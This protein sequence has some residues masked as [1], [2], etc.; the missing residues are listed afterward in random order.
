M[1]LR[2]RLSRTASL[3]RYHHPSQFA[4]R[5]LR[6][7]QRQVRQRVPPNFVFRG[8]ANQCRWRDGA[9]VSVQQIARRRLGLWPA[10]ASHAE[11]IREGKFCFLDETREL[12]TSLDAPETLLDWNPDAPRLWRFHLQCQENL[13]EVSECHGPDIAYALVESW[14]DE[15]RHAH[16]MGD[17]DAWHPFCISRRLPVWLSLAAS[18]Q[19]PPRVFNRFWQAIA[20]QT[21]W[22][23]RNCEWDLGGNHLIENLTSLILADQFLQFDQ[24]HSIGWAKQY[25]VNELQKQILPS[26]EHFER[27][28]TYH[29]LMLVS[30]LQ[31]HDALHF[32]NDPIA[33]SLRKTIRRMAAFAKSICNP[34]GRLPLLGDSVLDETPRMDRLL[35]WADQ[36]TAVDKSILDELVTSDHAPPKEVDYWIAEGGQR[37]WLLLDRGPLACDHLP[38]HGHSDLLQLVA[39]IGGKEAIVDTGNYQY[40]AGKQRTRCRS[41]T[42]HNVMQ[43]DALEH[44][45]HWS[46]F[47]MGRRGHITWKDSGQAST[48][49]WAAAGHDGFGFPVGRIVIAEQ[50]RWTI[51]DW[52]E[53]TKEDHVAISR[54]HW[55]PQWTVTET[56]D[57][58][59]LEAVYQGDRPIRCRVQRLGSTSTLSVGAAEYFPNFGQRI[60]NQVLELQDEFSGSGWLGYQ[61]Q[62]NE[63]GANCTPQVIQN[64]IRMNIQIAGYPPIE[65]GVQ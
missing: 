45:D 39:S 44:C 4:W 8:G 20:D 61:I 41:T 59:L 42:A 34:E 18:H 33:S 62:L 28:P 10:R 51:I 3:L 2:K 6:V 65:T 24:P 31:C 36:A 40:E 64:G 37:N 15:P 9:I 47:R 54:L 38:A 43:V 52:F 46:S 23:S 5:L 19:P 11:T 26:G 25:L 60:E 7:T 29:A 53:A 35:E 57:A 22:L 27:A 17:P 1:S 16:P 56:G 50:A 12:G 30:V 14:L 32:N 55:H 58:G 13:L 63:T 49:R 48:M 21:A